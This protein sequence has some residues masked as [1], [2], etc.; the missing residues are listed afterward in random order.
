MASLRS[1]F[2]RVCVALV[3]L[4][5]AT[6]RAVP[7]S[8]AELKAAFLVAFGDFVQW[9]ETAQRTPRPLVIAVVSAPEIAEQLDRLSALEPAERRIE[10]LRLAH[11][12][13]QVRCHVLYVPAGSEDGVPWDE[14]VRRAILIVGES[15]EAEASGGVIRFLPERNRVRLRINLPAA[16]ERGLNISS[17]LLRVAEVKGKP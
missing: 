10:V 12:S 11:V 2:G 15:A 3:L 13:P 5:T 16:T 6:A 7:P 17:R 4:F 9:P 8:S 1:T 14:L